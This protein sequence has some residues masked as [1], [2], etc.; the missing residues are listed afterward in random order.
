M[1]SVNLAIDSESFRARSTVLSKRIYK[2]KIAGAQ[3]FPLCSRYFLSTDENG[4][5][6]EITPEKLVEGIDLV[7]LSKGVSTRKEAKAQRQAL[8]RA[9]SSNRLLLA[10]A[11]ADATGGMMLDA[12]SFAKIAATGG[13]IRRGDYQNFL[14]TA[15]SEQKA[16]MAAR[17]GIA[18]SLDAV[19]FEDYASAVNRYAATPDGGA[20]I[21]AVREA[22]K[23]AGE[24]AS[25][26]NEHGENLEETKRYAIKYPSYSE[27]DVAQNKETLAEMAAVATIGAAKLEKSGKSPTE[28]FNAY[29]QSLGNNIKSSVFGDIALPKASTKS[30]IRHGITAEKIAS[31]EAIPDVIEKGKVIFHKE[32]EGG[33]ERIVVAAPIKIGESDYYMG[34]ML[35]RDARYQRLYLHNVA[36]IAIQKEAT[37]FSKDNL[38]TTGA[39]ENDNHLSMTSIL[40]NAIDV[41]LQKQK[42]SA[43]IK[44]AE[45]STRRDAGEKQT[46][47]T[48][49]ELDAWAKDN[50]KKYNELLP[51]E[52]REIRATVR[53][54]R[55]L[56]IPEADVRRYAN[57]SARARI[58]VSFSKERCYAGMKDGAKVYADGFYDP[59][60]NEIVVNPEGKRSAARLILHE[61][62]H[63]LYSGKYAKVLDKAVK[64]MDEERGKEV[65]ERYSGF[66]A[67]VISEEISVHHAED[68][69]GNERNLDRLLRD[70]P[71]IVDKILSFFGVARYGEDAKLSRAAGKL[72]RHFERA[73]D[74]VSE[75][76]VGGLTV[77]SAS[78]AEGRRYAT[79]EEYTEY[80]K[81]IT[82]DD[83]A[84]LRSFGRHSIND[85][86]SD[87]K[88]LPATQKWAHKF[89][90]E[91][92]TKSPFFRA[93]FGDWRANQIDG[94][95][96]FFVDTPVISSRAEGDAYVRDG[97]KNK[98]LYRG[99]VVNADTK[100]TINIGAQVYNDSLTY[101]NREYSRR[102]DA[103]LYKAE[104]TI[105][106]M[107]E[108][109][110]RDSVLF[111][112]R[113][114]DAE[115]N[116]QDRSFMHYFYSLATVDGQSY[117]VKLSVD[118]LESRSGTIRRAYNVDDIQI[119]PVAVTQVYKPAVTTGDMEGNVPPTHSISDLHAIVKQYDK[120]FSPKP[121]SEHLLNED[122]TPKV[123]YH[124]T[125]AKFHSFDP[126]EIAAREGSFF[127]A[128][129]REDASAYGKNIYEV[130]LTGQKLA[131][132]DNQ[133]TEFYKL[134]S[135]KE[136][137]AWLKKRGYDGWYA[138]MDSDGWGEV[139]VFS[140]EQIKAATDNIGTFDASNPDIRFALPDTAESVGKE[141]PRYEPSRKEKFFTMKDRAYMETVDEMYGAEKYLRKVGG[142]SKAEAEVA[143]QMARSTMNQ[144]QAMIG[145]VQYNVF[146]E[147]PERMGDGLLEIY[148]PVKKWSAEKQNDF[149]LLLLH[150]L[151][152][153]RMTLEQRSR[154]WAAPLRNAVK[155]YEGEV[156]ALSEELKTLRA[157]LRWQERIDAITSDI[158]GISQRI[159]KTEKALRAKETA[160]KRAQADYDAAII[161][162][163]PVFGK[164]ETLDENGNMRRDHDVT[165]A[166]SRAFI[167][168]LKKKYGTD[169][170]IF[171]ATADKLYGYLDNLQTM[172]VTAGLIS[173]ESADHMK[174]LYPHYV[175]AY[176]VKNGSGVAPV[177][178]K[179]AM[180][181]ATTVR[182]AKG[183]NADIVAVEQSI[184]EQTMEL[185]KAGQIN[186]LAGKVY[187]AAKASGDTTYVEIL[188]EST[189]G[190]AVI[191][192]P[193][194]SI[195]AKRI[196]GVTG[197][198]KYKIIQEYILEAFA[199]Q[200]ITLN[201]GRKAV[202][203]R[204]DALHIANKSG[205]KKTAQI[206]KIKELVESAQLYAEETNP[207]HNKFN[208]FCYYKANI[209]YEGETFPVYLNVGRAKNDSSYHIYDVT[210]KIRDTANR[211][212]GFERPKPNEGYAQ[213]IDVSTI[214]IP[215]SDEKINPLE[216]NSEGR[217]VGME[218]ILRPKEGQLTFYR[219][220]KR[221]TMKVS[222]ELLIAFEGVR[223]PSVEPDNPITQVLA[224]LNQ[225]FK[226]L[227]TSYNPLFG[228]RCD[229]VKKQGLPLLFIIWI[230]EAPK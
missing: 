131:D 79:S 15:T 81:L 59:K 67:E 14:K 179:N 10:L 213:E 194:D 214:S 125:D 229:I 124:G 84:T 120:E 190:E 193:K 89:Y 184:A 36:N 60:T 29:F 126:N 129:N 48:L 170:S 2:N 209:S 183:G 65:A 178:G 219:D 30:E 47:T 82:A 225:R 181:V 88:F 182:R 230:K 188:E 151:N 150:R 138:D 93:W 153:D 71:T 156:Q 173:Q 128:E 100:F 146:S 139:S 74:A 216:E 32:K 167:D 165:A 87:P 187:D 107:L 215:D 152:I 97:I 205:S 171:E 42:N 186:L 189:V 145:S 123:F 35:Q 110:V 23:N 57:L 203:D 99:D 206:A 199:D 70:E 62:S 142:L 43:K 73:M 37:T 134:K 121:V 17:L 27:Q 8:R 18:G 33:V 204:S 64:H 212:D 211:I 56:G 78:N 21:E 101:A 3:G 228:L 63:A 169:F 137:V 116:V 220:G 5:L 9:I 210:Q 68:V 4:N 154:A 174:K 191:E 61:L 141:R 140:P 159:K 200:T 103:E 53:R 149:E 83:I 109:I 94:V 127:F 164:D 224:W 104:I 112:T 41:K 16:A 226:G 105:L 163:R 40:Q 117:L 39:L 217:Y 207:E 54:A 66:G 176:R 113:I 69:L 34:V 28:L 196:A 147:K 108:N 91:L 202:V 90:R 114:V 185:M 201:D 162:N 106:S 133:P 45:S 25:I 198:A 168:S 130:Y 160:L 122:G 222:K 98:T 180:E 227:V 86:A 38:V 157:E 175:P 172:R 115:A 144:A 6:M 76:N 7:E 111:D 26:E 148:K 46:G 218:E 44:I 72:F 135:K 161:P 51:N 192:L 31:M 208:Y 19:S 92:G 77:E 13:Y 155:T 166:E 12:E 24:T 102:K 49:R 95:A 158:S 20:Y 58:R 52:K 80:D 223:S 119:S 197:S 136:Q 195:L 143:A 177:K 1:R 75:R 132:Y 118:E 221:V 22:R 96:E 55:A 85:L 50:V 11:V